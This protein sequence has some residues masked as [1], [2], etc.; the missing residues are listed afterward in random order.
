VLR[1]FYIHVKMRF[2]GFAPSYPDFR[3]NLN[4][5]SWRN[6][7]GSFDSCL[8]MPLAFSLR[9]VVRIWVTAEKYLFL[10]ATPTSKLVE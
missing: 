10:D 9:M 1:E 3:D 5:M 4:G 6:V 2:V 8:R 7:R